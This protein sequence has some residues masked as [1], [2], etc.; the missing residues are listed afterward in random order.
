V[1]SFDIQSKISNNIT[2]QESWEGSLPIGTR[3][4]YIFEASYISSLEQN[5]TFI[6]VEAFYPNGEND[7]NPANNRNCIALENKIKVLQVY[8]NPSRDIVNIDI[9]L[10]KNGTVSLTLHDVLG[11]EIFS[12]E[13]ELSKGYNN[14]NFTVK[15]LGKG[16]YFLE[17]TF[18]EE[19]NIQ[20]LLV[21]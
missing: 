9:I 8:P 14:L 20:K 17:T 10:P 15:G 4:N 2:L 7:D 16:V 3:M 1:S 18:E 5:K 19:S 11:A 12:Y 13:N 21:E 6:C